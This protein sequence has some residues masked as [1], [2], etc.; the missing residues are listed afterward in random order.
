MY[1]AQQDFL[2]SLIKVLFFLSYEI[3]LESNVRGKGLGKFLMQILEM[4][5]HRL[6][7]D[8]ILLSRTLVDYL[9]LGTKGVKF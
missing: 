3:Q 1:A 8:S 9:L 5:A 6:V 7:T 4:M 2:M